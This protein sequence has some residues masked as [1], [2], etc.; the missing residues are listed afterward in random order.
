MQATEAQTCPTGMVEAD[1]EYRQRQR[2]D[3]RVD[4]G[5]RR[6]AWGRNRREV[7]TQTNSDIVCVRVKYDWQGEGQ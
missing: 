1:K 3:E 5:A 4:L 7:R 2:I 6:F